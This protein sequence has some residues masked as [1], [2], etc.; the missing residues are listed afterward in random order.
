VLWLTERQDIL[1]Y[2]NKIE[3]FERCAADLPDYL[4]GGGYEQIKIRHALRAEFS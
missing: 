3:V 4:I 2:P 1:K